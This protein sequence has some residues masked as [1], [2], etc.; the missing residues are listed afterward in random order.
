MN[1]QIFPDHRTEPTVS[2]VI[3]ARNEAR[4][5]QKLLPTLP[6]V[7]QV[8]LVDGHSVDNTVA[9]A[10]HIM[11][12]IDIV[13]QTRTGKGNALACGFAVATGDIII[14][15]DADGSADPH[16]IAD[17]V[18][19]LRQGADVAK[20]SRFSP[21]GGSADITP[22]RS[23]G[24]HMLCRITNMLLG[25]R[26]TDLCYGYNAF[27]TRLVPL[28][29]LP[30]IDRTA[31]ADGR[32]YWGDGFEIETL[33]TC[34][35]AAAH[36]AITE[37]ASVERARVFGQSNLHAVGDG[38]RVLKTIWTEYRRARRAART[39][40]RTPVTPLAA[41]HPHHRSVAHI[42]NDASRPVATSLAAEQ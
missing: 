14:M 16:E 29:D 4:N 33:L 28:L 8:I 37:V 38:I 22:L 21:G 41:Q 25:T 9:V 3:P 42:A 10:Q 12:T 20:G 36:L 19:A 34:R 11:P 35:M 30:S 24:N 15:F 2:I 32:M 39:A 40:P 23:A 27:W 26:F 7:H 31:R 5:L 13:T 17:F 18:N 6:P 1:H